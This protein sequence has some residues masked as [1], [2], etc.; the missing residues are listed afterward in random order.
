MLEYGYPFEDLKKQLEAQQGVDEVCTVKIDGFYL[1]HLLADL[2]RSM[3]E[4]EDEAML[5][6]LDDQRCEI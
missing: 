5:D 1:D 6:L 3:K 2:F 4:V